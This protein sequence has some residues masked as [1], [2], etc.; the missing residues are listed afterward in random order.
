V[1]KYIQ[2]PQLVS[3]KYRQ[4]GYILFAVAEQ[5]FTLSYF[6]E[7]RPAAHKDM[8]K[9][10]YIAL[11]FGDTIAVNVVIFVHL[12]YNEPAEAF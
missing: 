11:P 6:V 1:S 12:V 2:N 5:L 4:D 3:N 10:K 8:M 7:R 9:S